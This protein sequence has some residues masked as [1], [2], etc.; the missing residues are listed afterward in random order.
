V[1]FAQRPHGPAATVSGLTCLHREPAPYTATK[2]TPRTA[3]AATTKLGE[4]ALNLGFLSLLR[5]LSAT[6]HGSPNLEGYGAS[7]QR[8]LAALSTNSDHDIF[9]GADH[10]SLVTEKADAHRTATAIRDLVKNVR[11]QR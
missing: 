5:A 2:F 9:T 11:Q 7:L 3:P 6:E 8:E 4:I 10:T 1:P